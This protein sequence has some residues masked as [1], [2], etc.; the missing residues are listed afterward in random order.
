MNELWAVIAGAMISVLP[1]PTADLF[2]NYSSVEQ[3]VTQYVQDTQH[4]KVTVTCGTGSLK[5]PANSEYTL[6]CQVTNPKVADQFKADLKLKTTDDKVTITAVV[7][8]I[9]KNGLR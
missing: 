3:S 5:V 9:M 8:P 1:Q 6:E 2:V 7:V 4:L